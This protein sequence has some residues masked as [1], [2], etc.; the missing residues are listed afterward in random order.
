[1]KKF[2]LLLMIFFSCSK[3]EKNIELVQFNSQANCIE[4]E[5]LLEDIADVSYVFFK[6]DK[7]DTAFRGIPLH[8]SKNTIVIF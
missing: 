6:I 1:M 7:D 8:I 4:K 3:S 5:F 2:F